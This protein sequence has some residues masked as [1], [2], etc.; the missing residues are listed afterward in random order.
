[1]KN[2]KHRIRRRIVALLTREEIEFI[3]KIGMDSLFSTGRRLSRVDVVSALIDAAMKLEISTGGIK[4]KKELTERILGVVIGEV[5]R[6][7]YPRLK[8]CLDIEFR[9]MDSLEKYKEA[10]TD[11]IGAGGFSVDIS[12]LDK[13]PEVHQVIEIKLQ[14]PAKGKPIKAIGRIAWVREKEGNNGFLMGV[15]LTY[16]KKEDLIRFGKCFGQDKEI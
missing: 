9:K 11:D 16:I 5:E 15:M 2:G 8:K 7:N 10:K 1:M 13:P 6:R 4:S 12:Y 14:D 3:E